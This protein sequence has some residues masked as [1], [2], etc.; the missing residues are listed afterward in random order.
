M[1][2]LRGD[3]LS[4]KTKAATRETTMTTDKRDKRIIEHLLDGIPIVISVR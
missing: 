4:N 1:I 3:K 2:L